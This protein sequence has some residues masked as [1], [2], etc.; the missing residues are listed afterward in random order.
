MYREKLGFQEDGGEEDEAVHCA[1]GLPGLLRDAGQ[2]GPQ[3]FCCKG[4][5]AF[6]SP[7]LCLYRMTGK[8]IFDRQA[9]EWQ[10]QGPNVVA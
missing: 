1:P 6:V 5:S 2:L 10:H 8:V 7:L 9:R 4:L 3:R